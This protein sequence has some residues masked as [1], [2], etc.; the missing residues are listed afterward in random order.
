MFGDIW[1]LQLE[2]LCNAAVDRGPLAPGNRLVRCVLHERMLEG[3]NRVRGIPTL[4]NEFGGYEL[5][6]QRFEVCVRQQSDSFQD[7]VTE[8]PTK[9]GARLHH[10]ASGRDAIQS[11]NERCLQAP[12]H[13]ESREWPLEY[14]SPI[15]LAQNSAFEDGLG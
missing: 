2:D 13:G 14:I 4:V 11:R 3:V 10:R 8:L 9:G 1:K 15:C 5:V 12:W 6:Q 7:F